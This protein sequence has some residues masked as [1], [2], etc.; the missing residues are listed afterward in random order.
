MYLNLTSDLRNQLTAS[1]NTQTLILIESFTKSLRKSK[2]LNILT[3]Q[4][5]ITILFG[6]LVKVPCYRNKCLRLA[7]CTLAYN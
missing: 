7:Q 5:F 1:D 2:Q 6:F 4:R 3:E